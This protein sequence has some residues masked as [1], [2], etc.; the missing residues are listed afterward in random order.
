MKPR[1]GITRCSRL[2][3]YLESVKQAGGDPLVLEATSDPA[4]ALDGIDGLLLTGGADVD[5]RRYGEPPHPS[6]E[7]DAQRDRFELPLAQ[8]A[9]ARD[10]P[11]LAICRG[12]Q[13]LNVAAGGTLIQDIPSYVATQLDHD[14][15]E[16]KDATAH[17]VRIAR[18]TRLARALEA[19]L[20]AGGQ[21]AVNSRHH[22]AIG[23]VAAPFIV[24]ATAEDGVIEAIERP[25]A[26]FCI[27]VQW[28]PENFW[29]TGRFARLFDALVAAARPQKN[30]E[31]RPQRKAEEQPQNNTEEH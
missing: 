16:P 11:L 19:S 7:A 29:R 28:H 20:N 17:D 13:V 12:V 26:R 4:Q 3:D 8:S 25:E 27:G 24:T 30:T 31:K 5:A 21:C 1:I 6:T 22:Q 14:V 9:L 15:K 23:R 18:E 2:D 10:T